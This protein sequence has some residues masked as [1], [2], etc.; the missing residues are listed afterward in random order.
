MARLKDKI[1][2][3]PTVSGM[4]VKEIT[5]SVDYIDDE[6]IR[7]LA[8]AH[9]KEGGIAILKGQPRA[10]RGCCEAIR[11]KRQGDAFYR[12]RAGI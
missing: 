3:N 5:S 10:P 12:T 11:R 1:K 7:P 6:V 4:R 8:K 2:D 9:H